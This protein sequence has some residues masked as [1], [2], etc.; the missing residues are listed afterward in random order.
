MN[1]IA[2][3]TL[4]IVAVTAAFTAPAKEPKWTFTSIGKGYISEKNPEWGEYSGEGWLTVWPTI[5][6]NRQ[7][8][9]LLERTKIVADVEYEGEIPRGE[10]YNGYAAFFEWD[11]PCKNKAWYKL[12][13]CKDGERIPVLF[14]EWMHADL[15]QGR[16]VVLPLL[17]DPSGVIPEV[18]IAINLRLWA[19]NPQPMR[20]TYHIQD[21]QCP[22]LPGYRFGTT[23]FKYQPKEICHPM[24]TDNPLTGILYLHAE[25]GSTPGARPAPIPTLSQWG[26]ISV[27]LLLASGGT[28]A[29]WRRRQMTT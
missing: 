27:T 12:Y 19:E 14:P 25:L 23:D 26:L 7:D 16:N 9:P 28:F 29:I 18:H 13:A 5:N 4:T 2:K 17:G 21:G 10:G 24:V 1:S 15:P 8:P 3:W 22:E 11:Y 20:R 6:C